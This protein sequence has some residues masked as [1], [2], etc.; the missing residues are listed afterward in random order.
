MQVGNGPTRTG[1]TTGSPSVI[2][3][4]VWNIFIGNCHTELLPAASP[5]DLP[6]VIDTVRNSD[7]IESTNLG[8]FYLYHGLSKNID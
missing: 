1:N 6:T 8:Y 7:V 2:T 4:I 5:L 3:V